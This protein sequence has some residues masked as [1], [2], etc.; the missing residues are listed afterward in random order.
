MHD[1]NDYFKVKYNNVIPEAGK[2]LI[3]EPFLGDH[4]FKRSIVL[5]I[6]H[7]DEGSFGLVLTKPL[8]VRLND[9]LNGF[10]EIPA[11]VY[12]GGPVNTDNLFYI[13]TVGDELE[14]S[15]K[16]IDG[17]YWGGNLDQVKELILLNRLNPHNIRFFAGYSGWSERQLEGELKRDSWLVSDMQSPEIMHAPPAGLWNNALQRLGGRYANWTRF[18][19]DPSQN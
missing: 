2:I 9:M 17:L 6:E 8:H 3:A 18:P 7:N 1:I 4:Y 15:S 19:V 16:I 11:E 14:G 10:P 5:L 13:H 12:L